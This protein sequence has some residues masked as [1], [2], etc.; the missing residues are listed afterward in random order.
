MEVVRTETIDRRSNMEKLRRRE[1]LARAERDPALAKM[2]SEPGNRLEDKTKDQLLQ[3]L[4]FASHLPSTHPLNQKPEDVPYEMWDKQALM[5][6]LRKRRMEFGNF[7]A[8]AEMHEMLRKD[9]ERLL[10]PIKNDMAPVAAH[11]TDA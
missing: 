10:G 3:I 4:G 11:L 5:L 1:L 8:E 2:F 6:E 9:D 7:T